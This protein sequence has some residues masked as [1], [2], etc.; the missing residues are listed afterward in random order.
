MQKLHIELISSNYSEGGG[1]R[2]SIEHFKIDASSLQ[3]TQKIS[4][5]ELCELFMD[6]IIYNT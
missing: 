4:K 2:H 1:V 3:D 6:I 5:I